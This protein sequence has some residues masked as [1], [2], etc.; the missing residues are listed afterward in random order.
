MW[1][2]GGK[3]CNVAWGPHVWQTK[4]ETKHDRTDKKDKT[5]RKGKEPLASKEP[6]GQSEKFGIALH[7]DNVICDLKRAAG[8]AEAEGPKVSLKQFRN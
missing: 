2:G 5:D 1:C 6:K 4:K 7:I 8:L 3:R